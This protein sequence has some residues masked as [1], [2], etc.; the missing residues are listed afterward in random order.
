M[1]LLKN[2]EVIDFL[3]SP[4]TDFS[5]FKAILVYIQTKRWLFLDKQVMQ[6]ISVMS[7]YLLYNVFIGVSDQNFNDYNFYSSLKKVCEKLCD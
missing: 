1:I 2:D 7:L 4:P 5:A 6:M 3:T